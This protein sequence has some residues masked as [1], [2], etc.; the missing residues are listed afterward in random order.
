MIPV[1]VHQIKGTIG[2]VAER[3][4]ARSLDDGR[5]VEERLHFPFEVL[6]LRQ[7]VEELAPREAIPVLVLMAG[8]DIKS[9]KAAR[10]KLGTKELGKD[11]LPDADLGDLSA[12]WHG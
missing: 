5:Y 6:P 7:S 9:H 1:H 12:P 4:L 3:F 8:E 11:A 2:I 10:L